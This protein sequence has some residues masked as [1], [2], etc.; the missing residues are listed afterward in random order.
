MVDMDYLVK[1][2][3]VKVKLAEENDRQ[4]WEAYLDKFPS[5]PSLNRYVW[6]EILEKSYKVETF[7]FVAWDDKSDICGVLPAYAVRDFRGRKRLYSLK[8]GLIADSNDI[9]SKLLDCLKTFCRKN[10]IVSNSVTSGYQ[11]IPV[12]FKETIKKTIVLDLADNEEAT[13][14]SLR[15]KTRNM[16]RK[17]R[18]SG[19]TIERGFSNLKK[20]YDIYVMNM[21]TKDVPIHSYK[22]FNNICEKKKDN[23]ELIVANINGKVIAGI[24]I[25]FSKNI[26][27]YPFQV[28]LNDYRKYAP[29]QLLIWEAM[30]VCIKKGIF[31]LDMG[32]S[33]EGGGVYLSK[34]NFGGNPCNIYYYNT[35]A[36][37]KE[38]HD[39]NMRKS[40][41]ILS[42]VRLVNSLFKNSP[43][44][45]KKK[46]GLWIKTKG[47]FI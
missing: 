45:L 17:A 3:Y 2:S 20:F 33:K 7:F 16:I 24:L 35:F 28:S 18:K 12:H 29:N 30:R 34:I 26:A 25:L 6:K 39:N 41:R 4:L 40:A 27:T 23:V 13:W 42:A 38:N 10:D 22:F 31:T 32:E 46:I 1:E 36:S 14:E 8:F 47:K 11:K 37:Q 9:K 5:N 21:L 44:W 19:L 43:F 15:D